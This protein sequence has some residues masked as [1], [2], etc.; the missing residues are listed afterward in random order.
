MLCFELKRKCDKS[1]P[2]S[3]NRLYLDDMLFA[4]SIAIA[5]DR[6]CKVFQ[7]ISLHRY[8]PLWGLQVHPPKRPSDMALVYA[9][10]SGVSSDWGAIDLL[11]L[12]LQQLQESNWLRLHDECVL[13]KN[14]QVIEEKDQ[15]SCF[16]DTNTSGI[17]L[18]RYFCS[19]C[20]SNLFLSLKRKDNN[21]TIVT[22]CIALTPKKPRPKL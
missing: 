2:G 11:L 12:L 3:L 13:Q 20:G 14:T 9:A 6:P 22:Y 16:R 18:K 19:H 7:I 8:P 4:T 5:P 15:L 1:C 17:L 21:L 10:W